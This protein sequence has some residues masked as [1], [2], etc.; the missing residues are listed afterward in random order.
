[1]EQRGKERE[2][3][4]KMEG[5]THTHTGREG[6]RDTHT[7]GCREKDIEKVRGVDVMTIDSCQGQV[8]HPKPETICPSLRL[9]AS[10]VLASVL[11]TLTST[12]RS[13]G[14]CHDRRFVPGPG[15]EQRRKE[16]ERHTHRGKERERHTHRGRE[17]AR[18]TH[19]H[20]HREG[21][22]DCERERSG[23]WM[24]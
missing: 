16:R 24:S 5:E 9:E 6:E 17:G 1:M 14:C 13:E 12:P 7:E 20:T 4:T 21:E 15:L 18:D 19:T 11:D 3:H 8:R 22:R 10:H 23:G 2:S